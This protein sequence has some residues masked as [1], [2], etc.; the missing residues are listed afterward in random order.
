MGVISAGVAVQMQQFIG[1]FHV[2]VALTGMAVAYYHVRF[3]CKA[4]GV[5]AHRLKLV[6]LTDGGI[7]LAAFV[8][9][10]LLST[11]VHG[12]ENWVFSNILQLGALALNIVASARLYVHFRSVRPDGDS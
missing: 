7:Y 1:Y 3:M 6:F 8:V 12:P 9:A 2:L 11:G 5:M 10:V 4:P